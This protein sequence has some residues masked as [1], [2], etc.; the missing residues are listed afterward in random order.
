MRN[1][2]R[3]LLIRGKPQVGAKKIKVTF[4]MSKKKNLEENI[5]AERKGR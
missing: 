5:K 3:N 4:N 2:M 1:N